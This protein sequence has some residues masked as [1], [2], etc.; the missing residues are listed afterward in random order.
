MMAERPDYPGAEFSRSVIE[1]CQD[2]NLNTII[3]DSIEEDGYRYDVDG[4]IGCT[5]YETPSLPNRYYILVGDPGQGNPTERNAGVVQVWD[6]TE[7]PFKLVYF[8]WVFGN[9]RY[10]NFFASFEYAYAKYR[11]EVA[12][13]DSTGTQK[14]WDELIFEKDGLLVEQI[15]FQGQKMLMLNSLKLMMQGRTVKYPFIKGFRQQL[16]RYVLPDTKLAQDI[17]ACTIMAAHLMRRFLPWNTQEEK[18]DVNIALN[19]S[20]R[21]KNRFIRAGRR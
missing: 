2:F 19:R 13:F 7:V 5:K 3:E 17:V 21:V 6:V 14:G 4:S 9:S 8:D 12:G 18:L 1:S 11:P 10:E 15:N 16:S 20:S